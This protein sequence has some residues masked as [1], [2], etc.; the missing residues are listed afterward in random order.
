MAVKTRANAQ[1]AEDE[2]RGMFWHSFGLATFL[3][4]EKRQV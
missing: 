2:N 3:E 1:A 4:G